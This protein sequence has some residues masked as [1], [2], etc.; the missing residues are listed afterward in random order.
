MKGMRNIAPLGI[1]IPDEL[2][3]RIQAQAKEN[4]RSTN[5]EIVQI[6]ESSFSQHTDREV[7]ELKEV[8]KHKENMLNL[9]QQLIDTQQ[10]SILHLEK[11]VSNLE[12][13]INILKDQIDMYKK[14]YKP[15]L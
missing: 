3:D 1:R 10:S 15:I 14:S 8:I 9:K 2:K 12:E 13:H 6:L 4:G 11:T 7:A 5:A